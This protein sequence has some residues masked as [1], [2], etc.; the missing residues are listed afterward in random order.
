MLDAFIMARLRRF[1][2]PYAALPMRP[3][4]AAPSA[5]PAPAPMPQPWTWQSD[6]FAPIAEAAA[7]AA[8][9]SPA[10]AD[11]AF[12]L[13]H[14]EAFPALDFGEPQVADAPWHL[15]QPFAF[16]PIEGLARRLD[17]YRQPT[18]TS[19][20]PLGGAAA[21]PAMQSPASLDPGMMARL[22]RYRDVPPASAHPVGA[23]GDYSESTQEKIAD[24]QAFN[25]PKTEWQEWADQLLASQGVAPAAWRLAEPADPYWQREFQNAGGLSPAL[26]PF[27]FVG[28]DGQYYVKGPSSLIDEFTAIEQYYD[29]ARH[30]QAVADWLDSGA[31]LDEMPPEV[32]AE[33]LLSMARA[34]GGVRRA[35][36]SRSI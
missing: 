19:N 33:I 35:S 28:P 34:S 13:P 3:F 10:P 20:A 17:S 26:A 9:P 1:A 18:M 21:M 16:E 36:C 8:A 23:R 5:P 12:L 32:A 14:S 25:A 24:V 11:A 7:L 15:R 2:D 22:A 6:V 27:F 29:E 4:G 30:A 31:S